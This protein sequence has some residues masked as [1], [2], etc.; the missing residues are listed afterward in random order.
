MEKSKKQ[1]ILQFLEEHQSETPS[2]WREEAQWR[3]EN[4]DWLRYSQRIAILLLFYMKR[5]GLTQAAM[6]E[7]I[8][9]TQQYVSKLLKGTENLTIEAIVKIERTT[10]QKLMS[11]V[12]LPK[13]VGDGGQETT[14]YDRQR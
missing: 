7:R 8:G 2:K 5:E 6:A 10:N 9:C 14:K 11:L 13:M 12:M 1:D 3:K 4:S